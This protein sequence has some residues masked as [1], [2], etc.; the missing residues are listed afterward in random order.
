MKFEIELNEGEYLIEVDAEI[1]GQASDSGAD[2]PDDYYGHVDVEWEPLNGT[3]F[4]VYGNL[5]ELTK[6]QLYQAA[7]THQEEAQ[8]VITKYLMDYA[9]EYAEDAALD[10]VDMEYQGYDYH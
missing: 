6:E 4:D 10:A 7:E 8:K 2:N 5:T 1:T 3:R 9:K